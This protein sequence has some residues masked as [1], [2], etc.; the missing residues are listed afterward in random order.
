MATYWLKI[1]I[2]SHPLSFSAPAWGDPFRSYE[3]ALQIR[4][5]ESS[6]QPKV[7]IW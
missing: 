3:K 6:R 5:L 4:K 1:A 2:F 7:K